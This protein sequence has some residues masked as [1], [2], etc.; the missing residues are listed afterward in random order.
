MITVDYLVLM[1]YLAGIVGVGV[2]FAR[3]NRSAAEMF[4]AGGRSP[5]WA[6]GLSGFMTMFSAGTFVVWGGIAYKH[7]LV[8]VAINLCY[9]VAALAVGYFVAGRWKQ[10]GIETPAQFIRMRYGVAALHFYTWSMMVYRMVSVAVAMYA[11]GVILIALMP[12]AE[13]NPLRD[14]ATGNLSLSWAIVLFGSVV[15]LYTMLG[16]LWAVLM[17]DVLQFIVLNLA[18]LFVVPLLLL[19]VG[20]VGTLLAKAPEGFFQPVGGEYTWF[21]LAGWA[22]IHFFMVGAEWAFVQRFLCV[23]NPR[24]AR[25]GCYLFG[26]LY[27]VSPWIWLLPPLLWRV[28]APAGPEATAAMVDAA[29]EQAYIVACRSVLPAGMVGL[30]VAAMF[31]A[32]AS[33]VSSQLNVFAGVLTNDIYRNMLNPTAPERRLAWVGR[34]WTVLLGAILLGIALAIPHLGGAERVIVSITSLLVVPLLA[35][36][37]WG[38]LSRRVDAKAVFVTAGICFTA[39][40]VV[41]FVLATDGPAASVAML[42][43]AVRLVQQNA[44]SMDVVLGVVLPV[45]VLAT[46]QMRGRREAAGWRRVRAFEVERRL[47][48]A[49]AVP[50]A[51]SRRPALIVAWALTVCG[52]VMGVLCILDAEARLVL[53]LFAAA[54][55]LIAASVALLSRNVHRDAPC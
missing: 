18:V 15:V 20:G 8:A 53:G 1:V 34:G 49:G 21:F 39:G 17:T 52:G 14:P 55:L 47:A 12:L 26:I 13:G 54:L 19:K 29:A 10:L 50:V 41:K 31:S 40:L 45:L 46:L 48:A 37:L 32:T 25:R 44:G 24:D 11:L 33:M 30:M 6:S 4:V 42:A 7:G 51:A 9:G 36:A 43:P 22:A 16:G 27:L 3:Q 38:L 23:P 28:E 5:W 2:L 35:P